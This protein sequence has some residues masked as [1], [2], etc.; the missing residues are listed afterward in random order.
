MQFAKRNSLCSEERLFPEKKFEAFY[1]Y[2]CVCISLVLLLN[3]K[4]LLAILCSMKYM[5]TKCI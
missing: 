5:L 1:F 3:F 2:F 4:T